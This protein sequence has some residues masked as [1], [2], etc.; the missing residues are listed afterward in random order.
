MV[1]CGIAPYC[2]CRLYSSNSQSH[3]LQVM[4]F[5]K[6]FFV[7]YILTEH[8]LAQQIPFVPGGVP[9]R[10]VIWD[11]TIPAVVNLL[12]SI[13][14]GLAVVFIIWAGMQLLLSWGDRKSTRL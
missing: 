14:A 8:A 1:D 6:L 13:A 4:M 12:L 5:P 11:S 3:V 7:A 2:I 10:N 9:V